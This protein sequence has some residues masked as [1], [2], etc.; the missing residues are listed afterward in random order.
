MTTGAWGGAAALI[1]TRKRIGRR[2]GIGR[3]AVLRGRWRKSC[4]FE[5]RRR[6]QIVLNQVFRIGTATRG[7]AFAQFRKVTRGNA[8]AQFGK[9]TRG[10]AFAQFG[11]ATRDNACDRGGDGCG[12]LSVRILYEAAYCGWNSSDD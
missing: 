12:C 7:N 4:E 10:N 11:K 8:F 1:P 2:G 3:H 9:V 5:S 6:H